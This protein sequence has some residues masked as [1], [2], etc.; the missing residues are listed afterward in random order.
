LDVVFDLPA[1]V[2]L[3]AVPYPL[4]RITLQAVPSGQHAKPE[5]QETAFGQGQQP[6]PPP[7]LKPFGEHVIVAG[8]RVS[9]QLVNDE[10]T[11]QRCG[12]TFC[13]RTSFAAI[14]AA[15]MTIGSGILPTLL[16]GFSV[17]TE[18]RRLIDAIRVGHSR[19]LVS[20]GYQMPWRPVGVLV[21]G[22]GGFFLPC[23]RSNALPSLVFLACAWNGSVHG[24]PFGRGKQRLLSIGQY[25][26]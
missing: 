22:V 5:L 8:Q 12:Q 3:Y 25:Q 19:L 26:P 2:Q 16:R 18:S 23:R 15:M 21:V 4:P 14:A 11:G 17:D 1:A 7:A 6:Q 13:A 20:T 10:A 9:L 24:S